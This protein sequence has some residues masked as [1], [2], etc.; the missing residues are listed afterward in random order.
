MSIIDTLITDRTQADVNRALTLSAKGWAAM[1]AAER[2][3]FEAGMKGAYNATDLNRVNAAMEYLE[4]RFKAMGY[5]GGYY[6]KVEVP[7]QQ[8]GGG[9]V[10]PEGYTQVEYIQSSGTQY[11]DTGFKPNQ[12]TRVVMDFE[13]L[14]VT[15]KY[16]DPIFGVR[17]SASAAGYYFWASGTAVATE[18]YQSGYN[19]GSTYPAV[20]RVGRHTVD[21]NKNV[22]TVDGV[23]TEAAYAAFTTAWNMLLFQSYNNGNLYSQTTKM[24]LYSCQIYDNG[25]LIRDYIPCI[26]PS[27]EVGLYDTVDGLFY[28]NEG[29]GS[30]LA[31]PVPADLPDGYTQVEYIQSSGT[32]YIDT[33]FK[34]N[35]NTRVLFKMELIG[36]FTSYKYMFGARSSTSSQ[37]QYAIDFPD[38]STIRS[39]FSTGVKSLA[40]STPTLIV[41][42]N[43]NVCTVNG[44]SMTNA[45]SV[46]QTGYSAFIFDKSTSG[47]STIPVSAKLFYCQLY[48]N[49]TLIRDYIPCIDPSGEAGLYDIVNGAFYGNEGTGA[50]VAGP[51]LVTLPDGYKQLEYIKSSGAQWIETGVDPDQ[52]TVLTIDMQL[53][54]D[55]TADCY[56]FAVYGTT[57]RFFV[58]FTNDLYQG[59][60]ATTWF[61]TTGYSGDAHARLTL[62]LGAGDFT[63]GGSTQHLTDSAFTVGATLPLFAQKNNGAVSGFTGMTVYACKVSESGQLIRD[64]IPCINPSGEVGLYDTVDGLFYG[65][66]GTG[67]FLAGPPVNPK[68]PDG[69]KRLKYIQANGTQFVDTGFKPNQNTAVYMHAKMVEASSYPS[70]FGARNNTSQMYWLYHNNGNST[71]SDAFIV[72]VNAT[73]H[74]VSAPF[75]DEQL[76]FITNDQGGV[77]DDT[78][79]FDSGTFQSSY[80]MYLFGVNNRN[81]LQYP[82]DMQLM[83]CM[84]YDGDTFIRNYVPCETPDGD[85]GLYDLVTNEFY[86][87]AGTG[88]FIAGPEVEAP[89]TPDEPEEALDPY[90]WYKE[91]IPTPEA[92]EAYLDN[93]RRFRSAKALFATT[94]QVP[95]DMELATIEEWN[96]IEQILVDIETSLISI[97]KAAIYAGTPYIFSGGPMIYAT[98]G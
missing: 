18:Q 79:S 20:T 6:Q 24:R 10:L 29:T 16:A 42:Q 76:F 44:E 63:V 57:N 84:I 13:L 19:N 2:E 31:A 75:G 41:D 96:D 30:F 62:T 43:K 74:N 91:D 70:L 66:E 35:N 38:S 64:Y 59:G 33:G 49:G 61:R 39:I 22:T 46:F 55:V 26:D 67:A 98:G 80:N 36:T 51:Q 93:V 14:S 85:I 71:P 48:D 4:A 69:Y 25:Q 81:A 86:G 56:P 97:A 88:A 9:S 68:L 65:N 37:D 15:G 73:S 8:S 50:F 60:L 72:R 52:D 47:N 87:N 5:T 94:P 17:T 78:V 95:D 27:G 92:M 3:E 23:T 45:N 82:A 83:D 7:H 32:Q 34:P 90:T 53:N 77:G 40:I 1:T 11:V 21:K 54:S 58:K 89:D 28:G 12:D